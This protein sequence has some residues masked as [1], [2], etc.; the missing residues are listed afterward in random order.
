MR[1]AQPG[2]V[3]HAGFGSN[4]LQPLPAP[5]HADSVQ[6]RA[7]AAVVSDVPPTAVTRGEAAGYE[8]PKPPSP[9]LAVIATPGWSKW[10]S[11]AA[12]SLD[13]S[14]PQLLLI[15]FAPRRAAV[16]SDAYRSLSRL[17][18]AS[19]RRIRQFGQTALTMSRSSEIS[20]AQSGLGAGGIDPP[21]WLTLRKH[22]LD[23]VHAG[24]P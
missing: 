15:A 10:T 20:S 21:V 1:R 23:D 17:V 18:V 9:E 19:T 3:C 11:L 24:R 14:P 13:S 4:A 5:L 7:L 12:T 6:P 8:T 2:S 22:P 16:S